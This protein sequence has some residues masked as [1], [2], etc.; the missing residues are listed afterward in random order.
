[1]KKYAIGRFICLDK[2]KI[3]QDCYK[4]L[5]MF[6]IS[7]TK[8]QRRKIKDQIIV[9]LDVSTAAEARSVIAELRGEVG[10]F[11][12]GLQL[13][14][15][16]GTSFVRETVELGTKIFLDV[17]FHDIPN[18]VAKA[19]K[20]AARLSVWMFNIHALGGAEM[21]RRSVEAVREVCDRENLLQPKIIG[22][23]IL[24]SANRETLKEI[25]I[26]RDTPGQVLNLARLAAK[27]GLDGIVAS[28]LEIETIRAQIESKDFLIVTPGIRSPKSE[29]QSPNSKT[30]DRRPKTKFEIETI[31]DQKRVMTAKAA[32]VA[33]ADYLVIGRPILQADDRVSAV[34]TIIE[35]IGAV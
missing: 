24:T 4:R 11:K 35:D 2:P 9:A 23:T 10:A 6:E 19:S 29:V 8:D 22:V 7:K 1:M 13:F 5:K 30:E 31:D 28:P 32:V 26:E 16:E 20:E 17:K 14:T 34:R 33:G 27:S 25:G 12:I 18:T 3:Y 21:M 15:A